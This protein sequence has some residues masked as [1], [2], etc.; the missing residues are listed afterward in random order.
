MLAITAE[1]EIRLRG[2]KNNF[3]CTVCCNDSQHRLLR[4]AWKALKHTDTQGPSMGDADSISLGR[5]PD[6][7]I[8]FRAPGIIPS[9]RQD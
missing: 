9:C 3:K 4:I 1:E 7:C 5:G 6:T 8:L 2:T